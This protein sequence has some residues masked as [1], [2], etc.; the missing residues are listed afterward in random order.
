MTDVRFHSFQICKLTFGSWNYDVTKLNIIPESQDVFINDYLPNGEWT[1]IS[2]RSERSLM[3][4]FCCKSMVSGVSYVL[5]TRRRSLFYIMNFILPCALISVLTLLVFLM[6]EGQ[7]WSFFLEFPSIS[8]LNDE[9]HCIISVN[10]QVKERVDRMSQSVCMSVKSECQSVSL[11]VSLSDNLSVK[12]VSQT[13]SNSV[14][15]SVLKT[16]S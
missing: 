11:S 7:F 6:P 3:S 9:L 1:L 15:W 12:S 14:S 2:A 4:H 13:V 16:S 8:Y 5:H 10:N